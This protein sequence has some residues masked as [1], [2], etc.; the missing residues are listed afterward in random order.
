MN[1]EKKMWITL[2]ISLVIIILLLTINLF[3]I[4]IPSFGKAQLALTT[5]EPY[6]IV[7]SGTDFTVWPDLDRCCFRAGQQL[8]CDESNLLFE[9]EDFNKVCHTGEKIKYWLNNKAYRYCKVQPVG[10][11][12]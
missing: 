6:C 5:G 1:K 10:I 9:S 7:Q 4:E 3:G 8:K 12:G 11:D 2:D